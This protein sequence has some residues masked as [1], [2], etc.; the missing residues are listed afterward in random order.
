[1][2]T[3]CSLCIS[4]SIPN[5]LQTFSSLGHFDMP[6]SLILNGPTPNAS[7]FILCQ[8]NVSISDYLVIFLASDFLIFWHLLFTPYSLLLSSW[9]SF[10]SL[11]LPFWVEASTIFFLFHFFGRSDVLSLL[12]YHSLTSNSLISNSDFLVFYWLLVFLQVGPS[13]FYSIIFLLHHHHHSPAILCPFSTLCHPQVF[14]NDE[15][16]YHRYDGVKTFK[17]QQYLIDIKLPNP[18]LM[19]KH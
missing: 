7:L 14:K 9:S 5:I 17:K 15:L 19:K 4:L 16:V 6:S 2:A 8:M 11:S 13:L 1:M 12:I 3:H 10:P 18:R